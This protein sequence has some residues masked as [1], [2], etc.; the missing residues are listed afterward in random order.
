MISGTR[1]SFADL[2][3][4]SSDSLR[5]ELLFGGAD[6]GL[7]CVEIMRS[8]SELF[9]RQ[10]LLSIITSWVVFSGVQIL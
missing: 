2:R 6:R 9:G 7:E 3:E 4:V 5:N 8:D 10:S 1:Q